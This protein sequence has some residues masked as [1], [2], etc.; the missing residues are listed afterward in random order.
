MVGKLIEK[1]INNT[2][3]KPIY[4]KFLSNYLQGRKGYTVFADAISSQR[5]FHAGVVQGGV[6]SPQMFN[7]FMADMPQPDPEN[8]IHLVVYADDVTLI[9]THE[10]IRTIETRAQAYLNQ[11]V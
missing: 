7:I 5:N 10:N 4:I 3:I 6:L 8:G 9:I 2:H 1:L 11:I